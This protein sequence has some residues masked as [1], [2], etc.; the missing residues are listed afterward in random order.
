MSS[1]HRTFHLGRAFW[2]G[3]LVGVIAWLAYMAL[4]P[5][6][7]TEY[8][9]LAAAPAQAAC[10]IPACSVPGLGTYLHA[11]R[12]SKLRWCDDNYIVPPRAD[13]TTTYYIACLISHEHMTHVGRD[14]LIAAGIT[15]A[16]VVVGGW[17]GGT[18]AKAIAGGIV[19]GS[20][21]ACVSK[22][23]G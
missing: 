23:V 22:I 20:G 6:N 11:V 7:Q 16:G 2:I 3:V 1:Q 17:V 18:T 21:A 13:L 19:G 9:P 14:C 15:T 4:T 8:N 12:G 5:A 10:S